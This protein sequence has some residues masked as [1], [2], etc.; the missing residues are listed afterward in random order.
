MHVIHFECPPFDFF[1]QLVSGPK[2]VGIQKT[3]HHDEDDDD[4]EVFIPGN[5]VPKSFDFLSHFCILS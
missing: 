3:G 4:A 5:D 2:T 1:V